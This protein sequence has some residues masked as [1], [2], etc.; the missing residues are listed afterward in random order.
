MRRAQARRLAYEQRR[1]ALRLRRSG[2]VAGVMAGSAM[3]G[4]PAAQ[5][6]NFPVSNLSNSGGGSL[7]D[8]VNQAN[9]AAGDD[10]ITFTGAGASGIIRIGAANTPIVIDPADNTGKLTITG[11]GA[12]ALTVSGDVN[13]NGTLEAADSQVFKITGVATNPVG[14]VTISGLTITNGYDPAAGSG[15]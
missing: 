12:G 4:V 2:L 1:E 15:G 9:A 10:T 3:F 5:G 8:A 13:S 7:R 6:A 11:P 14:S